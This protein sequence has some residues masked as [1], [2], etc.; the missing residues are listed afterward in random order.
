MGCYRCFPCN[1]LRDLR[2]FY[3]LSGKQSNRFHQHHAGL[4]PPTRNKLPC[5]CQKIPYFGPSLRQRRQIPQTS[6]P[7]MLFLKTICENQPTKRPEASSLFGLQAWIF[8]FPLKHDDWV[9]F[10]YK[11]IPSKWYDPEN[12]EFSDILG[13]GF[14]FF[15]FHPYLGKMNPFWLIFFKWVGSTTN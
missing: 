2:W 6:L 12:V 11:G 10:F 4:I 3:S 7:Q 14:N 1:M 8:Q 15:C 9:R 13:G 5:C